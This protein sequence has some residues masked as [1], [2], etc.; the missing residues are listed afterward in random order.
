MQSEMS[1][2]LVSL[3]TFADMAVIIIPIRKSDPTAAD[4]IYFE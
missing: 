4:K 2:I 1:I 3:M